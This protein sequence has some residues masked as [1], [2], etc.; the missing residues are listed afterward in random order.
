MSQSVTVVAPPAVGRNSRCPCGSMR[1]FK[2][3]CHPSAFHAE[4]RRLDQALLAE[5]TARL[6]GWNFISE[7]CPQDRELRVMIFRRD[8]SVR[9]GAAIAFP[10]GK[11]CDYQAAAADLV[12]RILEAYPSKQESPDA[13]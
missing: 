12:D 5:V 6:P 13:R 8:G 3:C 7:V 11:P 2:S 9:I 10:P 4:C 1:K